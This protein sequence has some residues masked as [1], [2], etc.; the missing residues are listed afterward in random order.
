MTASAIKKYKY[1]EISKEEIFMFNSNN[2][3]DCYR[4]VTYIEMEIDKA[5]L[6]ESFNNTF[7]SE[8]EEFENGFYIAGVFKPYH[9]TGNTGEENA[10]FGYPLYGKILTDEELSE[11]DGKTKLMPYKIIFE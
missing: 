4:Y 1:D 7:G 11:I 2:N 10:S 3:A 5:A 8:L 9:W 6:V